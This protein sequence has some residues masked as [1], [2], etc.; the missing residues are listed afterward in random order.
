MAAPND[1]QNV[2]YE[3]YVCDSYMNGCLVLR[4]T[5]SNIVVTNSDIV[6]MLD[7]SRL[8]AAFNAF[9]S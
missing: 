3:L 4:T 1:W 8:L 6:I 5:N 9:G 2:C 7:I